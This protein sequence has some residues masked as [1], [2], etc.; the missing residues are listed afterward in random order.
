MNPKWIITAAHCV[1]SS[2][3][4]LQA[5]VGEHDRSASSE[6][7]RAYDV[8]LVVN[9]EEYG[10]T[11]QFDADIAILA[12]SEK[13]QYNERVQPACPPEADNQY[14]GSTSTISGWGTLRSGGSTLPNILQ[15]IN[16][17]VPTNAA[18]AA[19]L[20]TTIT[21]GMICAGNIP[22]NEKD[23]CQGDSGG[24]MTVK[25]SDGRFELVGLVSWGRGCASGT[26]GVYARV[27]TYLDWL[28]GKVVGFDLL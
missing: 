13:I 11:T 3:D 7:R 19:S 9:H 21:P 26:P 28:E 15:W 12:L 18:C 22:E 14:V 20:S 23:S 5:V 10:V 27:S 17:P 4:G 8:I 6:F 24:P 25:N 16:S 1:Q 2:T